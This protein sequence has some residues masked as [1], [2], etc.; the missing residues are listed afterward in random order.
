MLKG[1]MCLEVMER[2]VPK[3]IEIREGEVF[4]LP[5]RIPHSPQRKKDTI[6]MWILCGDLPLTMV[7]QPSFSVLN[8][9]FS[10]SQGL[11][12]ERERAP[13]ELDGLRYY[14]PG[15]KQILYERWFHCTDLGTQL[16]PIIKAFLDSNEH[17]TG[18]PSASNRLAQAHS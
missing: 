9:P 6:G 17:R 16:A 13:D 12:I 8:Y 10:I 3:S 2:G 5:A 7:L 1:D 11:V 4:L 18:V 15:T 14:V